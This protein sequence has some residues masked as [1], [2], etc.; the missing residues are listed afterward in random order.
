MY[1][2][3][4]RKRALATPA[5]PNQPRP[6]HS[7]LD[8][9]NQITW[10]K[11]RDRDKEEEEEEEEEEGKNLK[12]LKRKKKMKERKEER[13]KGRRG[14]L[15]GKFETMDGIKAENLAGMTVNGSRSF[16]ETPKNLNES[17]IVGQ[18]WP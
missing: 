3:R 6:K 12:N 7:R 16:N 13:K 10:L 9:L 1:I 17:E 14:A 2:I 4:R 5:P 15:D 11:D 8:K 18:T